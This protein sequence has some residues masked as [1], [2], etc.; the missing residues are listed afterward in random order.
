M[1]HDLRTAQRPLAGLAVSAASPRVM[2]LDAHP[3][4]GPVPNARKIKA[5]DAY[6]AW[7]RKEAKKN[8]AN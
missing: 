5:L 1:R 6:F 3:H 7:L 4:V 2:Y 8:Q